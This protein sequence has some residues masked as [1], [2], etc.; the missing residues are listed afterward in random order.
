MKNNVYINYSGA[1]DKTGGLLAKALDIQGGVKSAGKTKA[2]V[3]GWGTK[4]KE[5]IDLGKAKV[6]NH[7]NKIRT[8]RNK[9]TA[10]ELMRAA[11]VNIAPFSSAENV[12]KDLAATKNPMALPV[13]GRTNYHQ[14]GANFFTCLTKTHVDDVIDVLNNKLSKKGYFQNYI[15]VKE[16]YRLHIVLDNLIYAVKKKRRNNLTEAYIEQQS[17]KI[18]R[19]A[20]KKG[21]DLNDE[22]L[23]YALEYQGK[24]IAGADN[25]VRSNTRGWKFSS[26]KPE[27]I[28]H[29]L[30][31]ESIKALRALE[32]EFGA[33]DCV[34][35]T[36]GKAW[37]IEVNTGPGLEGTSFK[38]YVE[39]FT[40]VIDD[41][42]SP[43]KPEKGGKVLSKIKGVLSKGEKKPEKGSKID[44]EKL[45]MLADMLDNC[46]DD[47]EKDAVNKVA[48]RMFG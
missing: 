34:V 25:I 41:I 35:D 10:L 32:L 33:V 42:L 48:Q 46:G 47:S 27:N 40:K 19:M 6:L 29:D 21:V 15:D 7:P 43:K 28:P 12:M 14:G 5:N 23:K 8:N 22:T 44:P 3:I 16:E 26:V 45:R 39:T 2:I 4:T 18:R 20:E 38:K 9:F 31:V 30:I 11:K 37:I 13:I 17:D 24:K 1:T 36:E